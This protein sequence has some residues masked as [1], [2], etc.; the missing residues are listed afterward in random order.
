MRSAKR[1][2]ASIGRSFQQRGPMTCDHRNNG[3]LQQRTSR[4]VLDDSGSL[5][6]TAW[7]CSKC[8]GVIEKIY[9]LAQD[10]TT[11]AGS[12]RFAV[13]PL[14]SKGRAVQFAHPSLRN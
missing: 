3:L 14:H 7:T 10:G 6:I 2:L 5:A 13:A 8:G 4:T 12:A 11:Q 9:I 1:S